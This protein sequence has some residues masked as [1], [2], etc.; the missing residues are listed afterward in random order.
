MPFRCASP[1]SWEISSVRLKETVK[2]VRRPNRQDA[3]VARA[4]FDLK[5]RRRVRNAHCWIAV[6]AL[7]R[8]G[9]HLGQS[10]QQRRYCLDREDNSDCAARDIFGQQPNGRTV[11]C[12][13]EID[14]SAD[15]NVVCHYGPLFRHTVHKDFA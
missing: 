15:F 4:K 6:H 10:H 14:K 2:S 1:S 8:V 9:R 11:G 5:V 7:N 3:D 13:F 12:C